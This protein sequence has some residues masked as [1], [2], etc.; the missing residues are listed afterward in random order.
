[1]APGVLLHGGPTVTQSDRIWVS[2][3]AAGVTYEGYALV[4]KRADHT[5]S[6]T[7]RRAWA[8]HTTPGQLAF[9]VALFGS[10]VWFWGH[11]LGRWR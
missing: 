6:H 5:L 9:T 4:T 1:M 7:T 10:A 8:V 3:I 11:V 2:I